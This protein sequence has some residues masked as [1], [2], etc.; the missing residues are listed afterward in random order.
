M[1]TDA[2]SGFSEAVEDSRWDIYIYYCAKYRINYTA[3]VQFKKKKSI[4]MKES[5]CTAQ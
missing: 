3:S 2:I 5:I 1:I 4:L